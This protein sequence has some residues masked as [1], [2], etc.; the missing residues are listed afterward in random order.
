MTI[1]QR[2]ERGER[3]G[4]AGGFRLVRPADPPGQRAILLTIVDGTIIVDFGSPPIQWVGLT[5]DQAEAHANAVLDAVR[6]AR[7]LHLP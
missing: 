3:P 1:A 6:V 5:A 7:T 2:D 4:A